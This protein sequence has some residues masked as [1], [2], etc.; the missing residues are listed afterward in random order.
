MRVGGLLHNLLGDTIHMKRIGVLSEVVETV[1]HAKTISV[2]SVG[3]KMKNASQTRSNV[4]KVDR[5]YSNSLL[6]AQRND[7]YKAV[8]KFLIKCKIPSLNIDASKL[9]NSCFFTL[10][11]TL[12]IK[13]RGLTVYEMLYDEEEQGSR[14]LYQKFLSE[15][16]KVLPAD[17]C[18]ILVTDAEFRAPW[19]QLILSR[20]WNFVGR[21]RGDKYL[22]ILS[23]G[24][25]FKT[26]KEILKEACA[27]AKFL[28][29]SILN[30]TNSVE[31]YLYTFK[32]KNKGRHA[33][34]RSGRHSETIK[35][36]RYGKSANEGWLLFSSLEKPAR[37]IVKLY[38]LRMTIEESFRDHKSGRYGLGLEMTRSTQARRYKVMLMI[39]MLVS[40]IAY[41]LG[42][43][44]ENKKIHYQYQANSTKTHRILSRFFLGCE[45]FYRGCRIIYEEFIEATIFLQNEICIE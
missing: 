5:L 32:N 1:L 12:Q 43:I 26:V 25:A 42:C 9:P 39:A 23:E 8:N 24:S 27:E 37:E 29:R 13:G 19:F 31:G 33:Y 6:V 10:R 22:Q 34:T 15:L 30:K 36:L 4:R 41:L 45:M 44:G 7:I 3:R 20:G 2:T 21:I 38:E 17:C 16:A 40:F 28:G 11:A 14:N 35:S 18:P